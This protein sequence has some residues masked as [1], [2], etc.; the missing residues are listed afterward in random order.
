MTLVHGLTCRECARTYPAEALHACDFCFG[1]L[2]VTFDYESLARV[3]SREKIA[4]GPANIWRYGDLLPV[5]TH[6]PVSL[7][8]G[9]TP[10]VRAD[11]LAAELGLG[12]L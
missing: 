2:E 6:D 4:S 10:L 3:V 11:R 8:A 9:F 12:E 5:E 7:G 1:P